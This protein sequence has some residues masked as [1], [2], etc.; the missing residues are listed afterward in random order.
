MDIYHSVFSLL[1]ATWVL[2]VLLASVMFAFGN[3]IDEELL[4][5]QAVGTLVI[6]SGL[7]GVVLMAIFYTT[8][9]VTGGALTLSMWDTFQAILVGIL[10][11]VWVVPYLYATKRRGALIAGPMFQGVP[12]LVFGLEALYG[13][14]P[15]FV[16]LCGAALVVVGGIILSIEKGED[17]DGKTDHSIDWVTLGYMTASTFIVALIYVLFKDAANNEDGYLA[18]GFW[19]GL[20]MFLA[21]I[22]TWLIIPSYR[23]TFNAFAKE[24]DGKTLGLQLTNELMD[25]GGVYLVHLANVKAISLGVTGGIVTSFTASQ[26]IA[27]ALISALAVMLGFKQAEK[28][29]IPWLA[30]GIA[31]LLIAGGTVLIA[32]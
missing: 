4:K 5:E 24:I 17:A 11:L 8:S 32:L 21:G 9:I 28:G 22:V 27:I 19:S 10:E 2:L 18:V 12:V 30:I 1:T 20:G 7:F 3:H 6:I 26:P 31:I 14:I 25:A 23:R 13:I 15:P 16:Q 29:S